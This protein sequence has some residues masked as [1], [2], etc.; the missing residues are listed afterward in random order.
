NKLRLEYNSSKTPSF[1]TSLTVNMLPL[2]AS[3][4]LHLAVLL[5][6][7][8]MGQFDYQGERQEHE[9]NGTE[10][11]QK[12]LRMA[13][14]LV[15]VP[16]QMYRNRLGRRCFRLEEEWD[17]DTLSNRATNSTMRNLAKVHIIR[18]EKTVDGSVEIR[19]IEQTE[20]GEALKQLVKQAVD[21][22]LGSGF[23]AIKRY[24]A[25]VLIDAKGHLQ[26][27][28]LSNQS[29]LNDGLGII[30][31][32]SLYT[33]PSCIEEVVPALSDCTRIGAT[34]ESPN[35]TQSGFFWEAATLALGAMMEAFLSPQT[36]IEPRDFSKV[37]R[38]FVT[39]EPYSLKTKSPGLKLSLPQEECSWPRVDCL[40]F[41][42]HPCFRLP[43]DPL[44]PPLPDTPQIYALENGIVVGASSGVA[45][46]LIYTGDTYRDYIEYTSKPE[47]EVF[48]QED[49]LR[50]KLSG[51]PKS[52]T[53]K[54]KIY[55][56][57]QGE[58]VIEDF[59]AAQKL[60]VTLPDKLGT[61]FKS[62]TGKFEEA[63]GEQN[64]V[65]DSLTAGRMLMG[66]RIFHNGF[67]EGLEFQYEDQSSQLFGRKGETSTDFPLDTRK[68]ESL[69]GFQLR[70]D[71]VQKMK[72]IEILTS[73]GRR[74]PN[75]GSPDASTN[76]S[77]TL[78]APRGRSIV[79]VAGMCGE[80]L[81]GFTILYK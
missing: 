63:C 67:V 44:P 25:V 17:V 40:R 79:G 1:S 55:S 19:R 18:S 72:G 64:L 7:D 22:H 23:T 78:V 9:E 56:A 12:K 35:A 70:I 68:G 54:L 65:F 62:S 74:S 34:A 41:R 80:S 3:P 2:A 30:G 50:A 60:S 73:F 61:A 15:Q 76:D 77:T 46:V 45:L 52:A 26:F 66:I 28:G 20:N 14:H 53:I 81:A 42:Y 24:I 13:A 5:G 37:N 6:K 49:V 51:V 11:V 38:T 27:Q 75:Y 47:R 10:M 33:L 36:P 71:E 57:G 21:K 4:P 59:H 31:S 39:K 32:R 16:E 48:L 43:T 69:M 58:S 8:S 29:A